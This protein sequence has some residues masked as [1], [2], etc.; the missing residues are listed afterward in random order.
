MKLSGLLSY[1]L[2]P[3]S[4]FDAIVMIFVVAMFPLFLIDDSNFLTS[5]LGGAIKN[6]SH[7]IIFGALTTLLLKRVPGNSL[8]RIGT[9]LFIV[10][11]AGLAIEILQ[12]FVRR[13]PEVSDVVA[14]VIGALIV[15]CWTQKASWLVWGG[16]IIFS[17]VL[18]VHLSFIAYLASWQIL[19][20][21][22]LPLI[23]TFEH[24]QELS[25]WHGRNELSG[26][27]VSEGKR[28]LKS[29]F[30]T[31]RYSRISLTEMPHDWVGFKYLKFDLYNPD[32]T[33]LEL[34]LRI[35]DERHRR[36]RS[37]FNDR[38]TRRLS[39]KPGWN[40]FSINL[41]EVKNAPEGREMDMSKVDEIA[42]FSMS[43]PERRTI[44]TDNWR[45]E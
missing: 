37:S 27:Y 34:T 28:S 20:A 8:F 35:Q 16:R 45:L 15:I 14:D 23:A 6:T 26:A 22:Q 44:Y 33:E 24:Y 21:Y 13:D 36:L 25:R 38:Y 39:I 9:V 17:G 40:A 2:T 43:L 12:K 7:F 18:F 3:R 5:R 4:K 29:K 42:L 10:F 31:R 41:E 11:S 1:W 32:A 30:T 19:I